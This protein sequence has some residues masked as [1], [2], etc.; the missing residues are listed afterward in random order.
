ML[1][2]FIGTKSL[3][4]KYTTGQKNGLHAFGKKITPPKVNRFG[5]DLEQCEPY[6][7]GWPWQILGAIRPVATAW[8]G[9]FFPKKTQK[10]LTK[11][12][13]LAN[14]GR[15]NSA[16]I[17]NPENSQLSVPPAGCLVSIFTVRI[18]SKSFL[19]TLRTRKVPTQIFGSGWRSP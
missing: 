13:G 18:N 10:V 7:A 5:W 12:P 4:F 2:I 19:C 9:S 15:H 11:F 16:M 1:P 3:Y 6:M 14:S 8:K 17:T